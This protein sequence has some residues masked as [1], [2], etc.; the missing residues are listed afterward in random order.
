MGWGKNVKQWSGLAGAR[1]D[2]GRKERKMFDTDKKFWMLQLFSEGEGTDDEGASGAGEGGGEGSGEGNQGREG[3]EPLSFNDFLK[4]EGNQA[5][6]DR[7]VTKATETAIKKAREQWELETNDKLS[8]AEKLARMT[9]EQKAEYRA[10][11][12]EK[13]I[14]ALK[15]EKTMAEMAKIARKMLADEDI[16]LPDDLLAH[17]ISEDAEK[18]KAAVEGFCELFKDAVQEQVKNAL[19]GGSPKKGDEN[20]VTKEQILDIKDPIERQRLIAENIKLFS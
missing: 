17:L 16:N 15:R 8:E 1:M 9:K 4:L 6:F 18:T 20:T 10:Q 12:M 3:N 5:E 13:E 11:Q 14:A 2:W 19:K 7:R